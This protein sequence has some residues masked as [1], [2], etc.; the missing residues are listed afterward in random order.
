[1]HVFLDADSFGAGIEVGEKIFSAMF[2][3]N[4]QVEQVKISKIYPKIYLRGEVIQVIF[5]VIEDIFL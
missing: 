4:L 3:I 5:E 2:C 1:M